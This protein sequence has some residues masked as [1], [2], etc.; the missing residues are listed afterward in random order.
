M[1]SKEDHH[2]VNEPMST[3]DVVKLSPD[4]FVPVK[5]SDGAAGFDLYACKSFVIATKE[6]KEAKLGIAI[7][8]P[9][10][11]Y[12]KISSRSGLA[13]NKKV[14]AFDGT[15][16]SDYTGEL[17]A[18]LYNAGEEKVEIR[19]GDRIGQLLIL[20]LHESNRMVE[21]SHLPATERGSKGFGS[22]G[23]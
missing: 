18:L 22:T 3:I 13:F 7:N 8:I 23:K 11:Y 9:S 14:L 16:D 4:A 12:G 1:H 17:S 10:G 15:I 20:K 21:V 19:A 6:W 2:V 5:A